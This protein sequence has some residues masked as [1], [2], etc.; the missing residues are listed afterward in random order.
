[1]IYGSGGYSFSP[2]PNISINKDYLKTNDG[3]IRGAMFK[4]DINGTLYAPTGGLSNII[5]LQD[6]MRSA[7]D[8]DGK[9]FSIMCDGNVLLRCYPRVNG[10]K[11]SPSPNNWVITSDYSIELEFEDEPQP[12][13]GFGILGENTGIAPPFIADFQES[14]GIDVVDE[15]AYFS[16][17]GDTNPTQLRLS[18]SLSAV[19]KRR[20]TGGGLQAEAWEQARSFVIGQLGYSSG[21]AGSSGV[22]NI[23]IS[24]F[25][26]YNHARTNSVDKTAGSYSVTEN[27]ILTSGSNAIEDFTVDVRKGIDSD[28]TTVSIQG[29]IQGLETRTYGSVLGDFTISTSKFTAASGYWMTIKDSNRILP[30]AQIY[31]GTVATRAIN[32][33]PATKS[34]GYNP[35]QGVITYSY[36]YNDR[37]SNLIAGAL[38]ESI[39]VSDTNPV[40]VFAEIVIPGRSAGALLQDIN[41]VTSRKRDISI[42]VTVALPTGTGTADMFSTNPSA[43]ADVIFNAFYNDLVGAGWGQIFYHTNNSSWDIKTGRFSASKGWTYSNCS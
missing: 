17:G 10:P 13:E 27:W 39:I 18:H 22:L 33:L 6:S 36:E 21:F 19:G 14:W 32:V 34:V 1:M 26:G 24:N 8:Q 11:F 31:G 42:D 30:R 41:T 12:T 16:Y 37:P 3:I 4:I 23:G 29:T 38:T 5:A 9:E 25:S 35:S 43:A 15:K 40:D 2:V 7:F 28:I 20:Y